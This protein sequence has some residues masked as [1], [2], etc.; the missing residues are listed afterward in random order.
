M[1]RGPRNERT[2]R[3]GKAT[4]SQYVSALLPQFEGSALLTATEIMPRSDRARRGRCGESLNRE[5]IYPTKK[6]RALEAIRKTISLNWLIETILFIIIIIINYYLENECILILDEFESVR[7]R[8]CA[9]AD[10]LPVVKM[11]HSNPL[12]NRSRL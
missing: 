9:K 8:G 1:R 5:R 11:A 2:A 12:I 3:T 4:Y 10:F 6:C 7:Y